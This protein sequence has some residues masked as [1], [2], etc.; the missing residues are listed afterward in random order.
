LDFSENP[1]VALYFACSGSSGNDGVVWILN[2][3]AYR[4][5]FWTEIQA[6][7]N[8]NSHNVIK[9]IMDEGIGSSYYQYPWVYKPY[10]REERMHSQSSAFMIWGRLHEPVESFLSDDDYIEADSTDTNQSNKIAAR[11]EIPANSKEKLL[12]QLDLCGI[13]NKFIYPGLDGIGKYYGEKYK[14]SVENEISYQEAKACFKEMIERK[15]DHPN[16]QN[17][18]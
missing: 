4:K 7:D 12:K 11:I 10:R 9:N 8:I 3:T 13:N 15:E 2:E 1:L 14:V 5:K 18:L 17:E 16:G 6:P